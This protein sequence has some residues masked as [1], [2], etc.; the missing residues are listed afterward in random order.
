MKK[1]IFSL[2]IS[3]VALLL[4]M[5]IGGMSVYAWLKISDEAKDVTVELAR[6]NSEVIFYSATD[7][8]KNGVPDLMTDERMAEVSA[9]AVNYPITYY[10]E[11]KDFRYIDRGE[12]KATDYDVIEF[13]NVMNRIVPSQI[14]TFK[15][16]LKNK[17]DSK[18]LVSIRLENQRE[19]DKTG[20][21]LSTLAIRVGEVTPAEDG[22]YVI[23]YGEY[24]YLSD[25]IVK[26]AVTDGSGANY[27]YD[28]INV[29][30]ETNS[31]YPLS[32]Y[33]LPGITD[34]TAESYENVRDFWLQIEM[35]PY[36]ELTEREKFVELGIDETTY[37]SLQGMSGLTLNFAVYF[38]VDTDIL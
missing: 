5:A 27:N 32:G 9:D 36:G 14:F 1:K 4:S 17:S 13:G 34:L 38:E 16:S 29:N 12:A 2:V 35:I 23:N 25:F 26:S 37:N 33:V 10:T 6:V 31:S 7:S 11:S 18:N 21:L 15:A 22:G 8:N 24:I 3:G 20:Q 28:F 19:T 30:G